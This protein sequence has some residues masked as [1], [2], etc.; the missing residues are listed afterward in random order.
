MWAAPQQ[1]VEAHLL[2]LARRL[3]GV[4]WL[5]VQV[6][7][8]DSELQVWQLVHVC[9]PMVGLWRRHRMQRL[10]LQSVLVRHKRKLHR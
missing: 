10:W 1:H 5:V 8:T 9:S 4:H 6:K 7:L 3:V 2:R